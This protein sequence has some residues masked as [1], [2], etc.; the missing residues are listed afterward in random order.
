MQAWLVC[1][2]NTTYSF[3]DKDP[4]ECHHALHLVGTSATDTMYIT[5]QVSTAVHLCHKYM[6]YAHYQALIITITTLIITT[7]IIILN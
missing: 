5:S 4:S 3:I 6:K 2:D 7:I 1:K